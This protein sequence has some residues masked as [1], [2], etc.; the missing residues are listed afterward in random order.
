[1][2]DVRTTALMLAC[3]FGHEE[4]ARC[5]LAH[6]SDLSCRDKWGRTALIHAYRHGKEVLALDMER[7]AASSRSFQAYLK[8][9]WLP[10]P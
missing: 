6:G 2:H 5:L 7:L 9:G 10:S 3:L 1:V 4:A 8:D